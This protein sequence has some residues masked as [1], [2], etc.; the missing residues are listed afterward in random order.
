MWIVRLALRRPY[1]FVVVSILLVV[2]GIVSI[3]RMAVDIFPEMNIPVVAVVWQYNDISPE[4]M[5]KYVK[6]F[7]E[8]GGKARIEEEEPVSELREAPETPEPETKG[9][10]GKT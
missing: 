3:R 9:F 8:I 5:E 4:E 2:L 6:A 7:Q 10:E 1:T